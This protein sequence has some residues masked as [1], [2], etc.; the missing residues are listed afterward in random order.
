MKTLFPALLVFCLAGSAWASQ[1]NT[2]ITGVWLTED[3]KGAVEFYSC[4]Q[5]I[6][7][8]LYWLG[9]NDAGPDSQAG[10]DEENPDPAKRNRPLCGLPFM[11]GFEP[12]Q[13]GSYANGWLYSPRDGHQYSATIKLLDASRLEMRGYMLFS[14]M[15]QSQIWE[16]MKKP[17]PCLGLPP[18]PH[19]KS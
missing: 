19:S 5:T 1:T 16:R 8:R 3:K 12:Q 10:Q 14:F 18:L 11:G 9:E 2:G 6:C 7:G 17:K 13:D 4:D 15:G